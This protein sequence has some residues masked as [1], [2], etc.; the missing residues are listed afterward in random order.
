MEAGVRSVLED[1]QVP[2]AYGK[3]A[4]SVQGAIASIL[5]DLY[6]P[7]NDDAVEELFAKIWQVLAKYPDKMWHATADNDFY[8]YW[9]ELYG[10]SSEVDEIFGT[11]GVLPPG[12]VTAPQSR[13]R[14]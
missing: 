9:N 1:P 10:Q 13:V 6:D 2:V 4:N 7:K 12:N 5:W 3:D 11:H 14:L 8:H